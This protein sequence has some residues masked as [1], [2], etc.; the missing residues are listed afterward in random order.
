MRSFNLRYSNSPLLSAI[1]KTSFNLRL[2]FR[3]LAPVIANQS[4]PQLSHPPSH[5]QRRGATAGPELR[6]ASLM[7]WPSAALTDV[8]PM[9]CSL[10]VL[11]AVAILATHFQ[12]SP[13]ATATMSKMVAYPQR[14]L[15]EMYDLQWRGQKKSGDGRRECVA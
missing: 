13:V 7:N 9:H 2:N 12:L 3:G 11:A 10:I 6:T 8:V 14:S 4:Y 5:R 1:S 15:H